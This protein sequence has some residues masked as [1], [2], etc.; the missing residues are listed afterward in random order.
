MI[1]IVIPTLNEENY[2]PKLLDC[3]K[4]QNFKDY[5][6]IVAD[7]DSHDNTRKIAKKYGCKIVKSGGL[8]GIGRNNGARA[9][10]GDILLF[11]DADS[12]IEKDFIG[13]A[14]YEMNENKLDVAGSYLYPSTNNPIDN[15]FLGIF[16]AWIFITQYFYPNAC[17][18][19][20]LCKKFV[21]KKIKGFDETIKL[22]EDMDYVKRAGKFGKFRIIKNS[23]IIYSMRRYEKEGRL[24]V[25]IKLFLSALHRLFLGE[26]RSDVFRYDLKYKK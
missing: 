26:I 16:N 11:L 17:G 22:S 13:N 24:K 15:I 19:G 1:S 23:K 21:H 6:V 2:L 5:E 7:A 10:K 18:T 9:A 14:L 3:I 12:L 8:P 20:I 4:K 25:G